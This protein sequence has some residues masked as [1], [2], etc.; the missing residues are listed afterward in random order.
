MPILDAPARPVGAM[1]ISGLSPKQPGP[2]LDPLVAM[3]SEAC[4]YVSRR[5]GYRRPV[6]RPSSRSALPER[7][8]RA[9][10]ESAG[11]ER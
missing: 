7:R 1:S 3:L 4:G 9:P 5:L 10:A 2:E 11:R 6:S 8:S